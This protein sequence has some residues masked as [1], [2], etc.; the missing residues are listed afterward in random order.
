[1][2]RID[3]MPAVLLSGLLFAC[4]QTAVGGNQRTTLTT[5]TL[6][7]VSKI[8]FLGNSITLHPPSEAIGWSNNWGMAASEEAKDYVHLVTAAIAES[9]GSTPEIMV[10]NIA[11]FERD[12]VNYNVETQ[13]ADAF[14][15]K[16]DLFVLAIGEN[17]TLTDATQFKAGI[18]RII[19][20]VRAQSQPIIAVR[21]CFWA[22]AA[23]D[24]ALGQAAQQ[25]GAIFVNISSLGSVEANLARSEPTFSAPAF[26]TFNSHPGDRG[27][28]AIASAIVQSVVVQD[29]GTGIPLPN[30][31]PE[32]LQDGAGLAFWVDANRN[33]A[34][35][36]S[37]T[38]TNWYDVREA[39]GGALYPRAHQFGA[40]L[41]PTLVTGGDDVAGNK[42]VD[43]GAFSSGKWLQW[44]DA[45]GSRYA[46]GNIR[47][48]FLVVSCT[49]GTGFL[50]GDAS[51]YDPGGSYCFH[52]GNTGSNG[53]ET[54]WW[55]PDGGGDDHAARY[56]FVRVNGEMID[57]MHRQ[58]PHV[59]TVL[60][61]QTSWNTLASN[62]CN[63]RN[64]RDGVWGVTPSRLGG[65]RIGEAL[66][67][68]SEL[69]VDQRKQVEDYLMRKWLRKTREDVHVTTGDTLSMTTTNALDLSTVTGAGTLDVV[70]EGRIALPDTANIAVPPIALG[71]GASAGGTLCRKPGQSFVLQGGASYDA[72]NGVC[73]RSALT[74]GTI[75]AKTGIGVLTAA[76]I[77]AGIAR[78]NVNEG[79]LRLSPPLFGAPDVLTN[80]LENGSF[81]DSPPGRPAEGSGL[82]YMENMAY[83]GWTYTFGAPGGNCGLAR[84]GGAFCNRQ[85]PQGEWVMFLVNDCSVASTFT[86]PAAGRY[87]VSFSTATGANAGWPWHLYQVLV[88]GTNVVGSIRTSEMVFQ[89]V[90]CRT[91]LLEAGPH[92]LTFLGIRE[93]NRVTLIDNVKIRP[94]IEADEVEVPN[95]GFE[96]PTVLT[97]QS[98]PDWRPYAYFQ[99]EPVGASWTFSGTYTGTTE[100]YSTWHCNGMDDGGHAA[101]LN[102]YNGG[103]LM[104]VPI[105][106]PA[107][108]VYR[109]TFKAACRT[110]R[111]T[112]NYN[113]WCDGSALNGNTFAV[114]LNGVEAAR[115]TQPS[116]MGDFTAYEFV[117][118]PVTNGVLTQT[119]AFQVINTEWFVTALIDDVRVFKMPPIANPSFE[120]VS[121][122][123]TAWTFVRGD[124]ECGITTPGEYSWT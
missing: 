94:S 105:T 100:G 26:N 33:A 46:I 78:I 120:D 53:L 113:Q 110:A 82:V 106:F 68:T 24:L 87:E 91:P 108:G 66:I 90:T 60:S 111:Y 88:D 73:T 109:I 98:H 8:L 64:L 101:V 34:T 63:D 57:G 124:V 62:F 39:E 69:S 77:D 107:D 89:N 118:P 37:G 52:V 1:M 16:P 58:V 59:G 76:S 75:A 51:G 45:A 123:G 42:L 112:G 38:V 86:V 30:S 28:A 102:M 27:M 85:P 6:A 48:V 19:N 97:E 81:E 5:D 54:T 80:A 56:G 4:V 10:K 117:L 96:L 44:Q 115:A 9:T 21:S 35:D 12:Y 99:H 67:Y 2:I 47:T 49:N 84:Y 72:T 70:G 79:A 3:K 22:D 95:S 74:D 31:L 43:F 32:E 119:L 7:G 116:W 36:E 83:A 29:P 15:F 50:L 17:V 104:S 121:E 23:K 114:S 20:G 25:A 41:A 14:A 92:T 122:M 71:A 11:D 18:M 61:V 13:L 65:G 103:G 55:Q 40:E 93:E